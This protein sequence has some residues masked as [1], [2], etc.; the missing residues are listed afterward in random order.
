MSIQGL[1]NTSAY[2]ESRRAAARQSAVSCASFQAR[3]EKSA[4]GTGS[5]VETH[6]LCTGE[7]VAFSG[8]IA[9]K[10]GKIQEVCAHYT[11][12]STAEDPV[13]RI[14]GVAA[15]GP[16][17]FICHIN[18]VDPANASYAEL[19][20]LWGHSA[21]MG[22][23][24]TGAG[25]LPDTME[26]REDITQKYDFIGGIRNSLDR[27]SHIIPTAASV[28]GANALLEL[29]QKYTSGA[30]G[31]A[32]AP[33]W[34]EAD[35]SGLTRGSL[36]DMLDAARLLLLQRTKE[37]REW[38]KEQDEW[39]RLMK[40]LDNWIEALRDAADRRERNG[41]SGDITAEGG[42]ALVALYRGYITAFAWAEDAADPV[43]AKAD[44]LDALTM[45]KDA[46]LERLREDKAAEEERR[47]W[48]VLLKRLDRWI[49]NLRAERENGEKRVAWGVSAVSTR[50]DADAGK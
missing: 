21:R 47:E 25:P 50:S 33:G 13:V 1:A 17:D 48:E 29:Y 49:E 40:C 38:K 42:E 4:A 35:G 5:E 7:S 41:R 45:A 14:S 30:T 18:G 31:A 27:P 2:T 9:G 3:L 32:P 39:D 24:V 26:F 10:S 34:A 37:G 22:Q 46:L 8:G 16:F 44:L 36:L 43:Q 11:E 12:D 20:A 23:D 15:S 19:A 6:H 28:A